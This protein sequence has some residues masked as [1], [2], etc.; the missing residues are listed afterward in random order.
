MRGICVS[1]LLFL[2]LNLGS[3]QQKQDVHLINMLPKTVTVFWQDGSNEAQLAD[4]GPAQS[5]S[6]NSYVGHSFVVRDRKGGDVVKTFTVKAGVGQVIVHGASGV[7]GLAP[8]RAT[9]KIPKEDDKNESLESLGPSLYPQVVGYLNSRPSRSR[10]VP[11]G[12]KFR[13]LY[14][15]DLDYYYDDGSAEGVY[16]GVIRAMGRS[17]INTYT[18]HS[19]TFYKK[20]TREKVRRVTMKAN[21][22]LII[23]KPP[24]AQMA[25]V[26]KTKFYKE[27]VR[28]LRF[29][30][31]YQQRTGMPWLAFYPRPRPILH[32]WPA[33]SVGAEHRV[34]AEDGFVVDAHIGTTTGKKVEFTL[35]TI[36]LRPRVFMIRGLLRQNE[37][38]HIIGLSKDKVQRSAVGNG[39][40][41]FVTETRTS[42]NTW[43]RRDETTTMNVLF[44][45]FARV[46]NIPDE[47]L[48]HDRT[49]ENLQ[50]VHYS[51]GQKYSPHHD[52]NDKG[53]PEQR[54]LTLFIY[55]K[56][57]D[58][59]GGTAFPL[60]YGRRGLK[61]QPEAG[62]AILWYNMLEDGNADEM[63]L[64]E[65]MPVAQGEKWAANLWVW[66]PKLNLRS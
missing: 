64:H 56:T 40:D 17:A 22:N 33:D 9:S 31:E 48:N 2:G 5:T 59:R 45:R 39:G 18:T 58:A 38:D 44:R 52:F 21:K 7:K 15:V 60:A 43:L 4:V 49:A 46:L 62:D 41:G 51:V 53:V 1:L 54:F 3:A 61:V 50:V 8:E 66:D 65:G 34:T 26:K 13:N 42:R 12:A 6:L 14:Q 63:S 19:F 55:L 30:K 47:E 24:A 36:A 29:F 23:L 57:A 16:N 28:E 37:V 35:R 10:E 32:M 20:G 25:A 27:V 11:M